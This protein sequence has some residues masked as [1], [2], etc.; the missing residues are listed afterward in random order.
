MRRFRRAPAR[1]PEPKTKRPN[2]R[3][4]WRPVLEPVKASGL[5]LL[6]TGALTVVPS[7]DACVGAVGLVGPAVEGVI[8]VV[9]EVVEA[10]RTADVVVGCGSGRVVVVVTRAAV[11]VVTPGRE[12]VVAPRVVVVVVG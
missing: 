6:V 12:V 7:T 4:T 11:V 3:R 2:P 10:A 8:G 1:R 5:P 9:E